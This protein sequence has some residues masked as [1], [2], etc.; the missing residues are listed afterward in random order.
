MM[1]KSILFI[2]DS[3]MTGGTTTA[4]LSLINL[5]DKNNFDIDLLLFENEGAY[6][7]SIPSFVHILDK[8][9]IGK[10]SST[11]TQK[12]SWFFLSLRFLKVLFSFLKYW[13]TPKGKI[14]NIAMHYGMKCQVAISRRVDKS[15]DYAVSF[16]EGWG[17]EYLVSKKIKAGKKIVWYHPQYNDCYLIPEIDRKICAKAN[18]ICVV[19]EDC[20]KQFLDNFKEYKQ[21]VFVVHNILSSNLLKTKANNFDFSVDS[22]FINICTICRLDSYVK[23]LD[24]I[25]ASM[26]KLRDE[27]L[28]NFVKWHLIGDGK[29][30]QLVVDL[31]KENNLCN[32]ILL[33]GNKTNPYPYLK[34]MDLFL[35]TSRYE[36]KPVSVTEAEILGVPCMITNYSSA[37]EQVTNG[38][39]GI[40]VNNDDKS[41]YE[42]LKSIITNKNVL[43]QYKK[44]LSSQNFSN[45]EDIKEFYEV[46]N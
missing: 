4:L 24:R 13:N 42:G 22:N 39:N 43:I 25:I 6:F 45:E 19:S 7:D 38:I 12:I 18:S 32:Y 26:K 40:I 14:R 44:N 36:G 37:S 5:I 27:N 46:L 21:K 29:D 28:L 20:K 3:M 8:A 11:R 10:S 23:G 35:L 17:N 41:I 15:Y 31:I 1:K 34:K 16:M 33:Y 30:Y 9:H 2:Y